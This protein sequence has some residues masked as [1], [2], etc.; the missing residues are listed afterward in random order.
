MEPGA[1]MPEAPEIDPDD[2]GPVHSQPV[3][4]ITAAGFPDGPDA[5]ALEGEPVQQASA[6]AAPESPAVEASRPRAMRR[7]RMALLGACAALI[8]GPV[9][10]L[11]V[12]TGEIVVSSHPAGARV[13][14]QGVEQGTTPLALRLAP[15]RHR[16]EIVGADGIV[17]PIDA[18]VVAGQSVSRHVELFPALATSGDAVL[19]VDTG[20]PLAQLFIDG[21]P[22]GA[23]PLALTR[24]AAGRHFVQVRYLGNVNVERQVFVPAGETVSLVLDPP[25]RRPSSPTGPASGWVRVNA[26]IPLDVLAGDRVIGSSAADRIHLE[27]GPHTLALVNPELG[28][29]TTVTTQVTAGQVADVA[30]DPPRVPVA[31]NAQP[32]AHVI[33]DG[34][35]VGDTPIANLMLPIGDHR[36]VLS[37]PELGER[38]QM[39]TVRATGA[40][41]VSVDL[42]R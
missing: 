41:R 39:V 14:L 5:I 2:Q 7:G 1:R 31:I 24:V 42:R 18:D 20:D 34:Q 12:A 28:F 8:L 29:R 21:T 4:D 35:P 16:V 27:T 23:T 11:G 26:P 33:V 38:V 36:V 40:T 32:W 6:S 9:V 10:Y 25:R 13:V 37:H 3:P 30:V 17:Q 19:V 15:G 22:A